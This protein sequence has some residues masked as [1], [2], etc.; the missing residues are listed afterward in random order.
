MEDK[1]LVKSMLHVYKHLEALTLSLEKMAKNKGVGS[2]YSYDDTLK[3]IDYLLSLTERKIFL[4]NLKVVM[5]EIILSLD[6]ELGK[7]LVLKYIDEL[8]NDAISVQCNLTERT[9]FRQ[10]NR[11]YDGFCKKL[12]VVSKERP[13]FYSQ[14]KNDLWLNA[15]VKYLTKDVK[16]SFYLKNSTLPVGRLFMECL[17]SM[18]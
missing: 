14:L 16:Q 3:E 11:A 15:I 10:L 8:D 7:L 12:Q 4:I 6:K 17:N 2:Y 9:F 5:D 13:N 18:Y 1:I